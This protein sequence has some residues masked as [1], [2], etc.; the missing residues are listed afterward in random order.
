MSKNS[1]KS[2]N[3]WAH[4]FGRIGTV[5]ALAYMII[6][7]VIVCTVFDCFP[8]DF[9]SVLK[10]SIGI[11]ALFVPVGIAEAISYTPILGSSCYLTFITGNIMNLKLPC[12]MNAQK[13]AKVEANTPEGDAISLVAVAASSILTI[14]V[15]SLGLVFLVPLRPVLENPTVKLASGYMLPSM[16]GALFLGILTK[17]SSKTEIENKLFSIVVPFILVCLGIFAGVLSAGMEGIS[18][19]FMIPVT[20]LCARVL[21]KKG[22]VRVVDNSPEAQAAKAAAKAAEKAE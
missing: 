18:L 16:F 7:P 1:N 4:S 6:M 11:F 19:L 14:I 3:D 17:G 10:G 22:I 13:I 2:F 15:I 20:I 9:A 8:T 21:W 5:I 12:V